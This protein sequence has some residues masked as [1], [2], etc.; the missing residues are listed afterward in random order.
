[1]VDSDARIRSTNKILLQ[2]K[3]THGMKIV[4]EIQ[5]K[6]GMQSA[7]KGKMKTIWEL[8]GYGSE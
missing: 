2:E 1:M 8:V 3:L 6:I 4:V 5:R 7:F